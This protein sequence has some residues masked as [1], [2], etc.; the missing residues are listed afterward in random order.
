MIRS[1][2]INYVSTKTHQFFP[3]LH[4]HNLLTIEMFTTNT[5]FNGL[6]SVRNGIRY[7]KL[8]ILTNIYTKLPIITNT[9]AI[10]PAS[11]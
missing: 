11:R 6:S 1:V 8:R 10:F 9:V 7:S 5:E 2:K 3:A 4:Y